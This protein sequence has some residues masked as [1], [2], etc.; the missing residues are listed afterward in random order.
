[1]QTLGYYNGEIGL[2]DEVKVPM[3]DR[4]CYFGDGIYD[5][6]YCRNYKPFALE[7][8]IE[9]F[10][11]GAKATKMNLP[12]SKK[13]LKEL[14]C[15]LVK[16]VDSDEQFVYFQATRKTGV[17][18]HL[19]EEDCIANL[20]IMLRPCPIKSKDTKYNI[21]SVEDNRFHMCN[22]KTIN[23]LPNILALNSANRW[24]YNEVVFHRAGRVTEC[25][26]SNICM[27]ID[28]MVVCCPHDNLSL[29]GIAQ[30]HLKKAC[31]KLGIEVVEREFC[32]SQLMLADEAILTSSGALCMRVDSIDK[33]KVGNKAPLIFSAIQDTLY[34][35]FALATKV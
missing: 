5:A 34:E 26:H 23:L 25:G 18:D 30:R 33:V 12:Q 31:F 9:R 27:L 8:H 1:M 2:L 14:I 24:G 19:F 4:G 35:E 6:T 3:L 11:E 21:M 32:L 7:E 10:F 28:G 16:K 22:V 20:W 17:R 15:E 29:D 13:Q